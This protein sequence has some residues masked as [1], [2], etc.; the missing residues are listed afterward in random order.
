MAFGDQMNDFEMLKSVYY[1]Y[2][3]D[4]AIDEVKQ[5]ARFTAPPNNEYGVIQV[6]KE[7]FKID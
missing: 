2:A 4:N 7:F 1:S 6:L 3:M 5:V